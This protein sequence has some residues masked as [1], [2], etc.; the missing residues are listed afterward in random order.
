MDLKLNKIQWLKM[1]KLYY[2]VV[3]LDVLSLVFTSL[4]EK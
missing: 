2:V 1:I 4:N 3:F